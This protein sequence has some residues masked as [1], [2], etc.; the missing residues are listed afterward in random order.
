M[1]DFG[2]IKDLYKLQKQAREI[3]K[4]LKDTEIEAR[5][6][7]GWVTV[8]FNGEQHLT[9]LTLSEEA[10]R[11]ENKQELEKQLQ[12][13]ISQAI[14]RSQALAAEKMKDVMGGMGLPGM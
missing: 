8:V 3:Q 12:N 1:V 10:L 9:E 11:P 5:S 2:K 6:N 7:D 4:E 13:T 14:S